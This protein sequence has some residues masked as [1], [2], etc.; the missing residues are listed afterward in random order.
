MK[1]RGYLMS[2]E[3]GNGYHKIKIDIYFSHDIHCPMSSPQPKFHFSYK[4][5]VVNKMLPTDALL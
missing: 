3:L 1:F 5:L 2:N 4:Y